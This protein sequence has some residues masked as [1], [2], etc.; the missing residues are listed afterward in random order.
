MRSPV[1]RKFSDDLISNP[2]QQQKIL[3][4]RFDQ[5]AY[6]IQSIDYKGVSL[7]Q[8]FQ[9]PISVLQVSRAELIRKC[10]NTG[11]TGSGSK[12]SDDMSKRRFYPFWRQK[13]CQIMLK[14]LFYA[15]Y[16]T[17]QLYV[18]RCYQ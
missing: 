10:E 13:R 16:S 1:K 8:S 7:E 3:K 18:F 11:E 5:E 9:K 14:R 17:F 15:S 2:E 4:H 12:F 6:Q